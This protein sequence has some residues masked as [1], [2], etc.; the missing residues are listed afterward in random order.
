MPVFVSVEGHGSFT[1]VMT[2]AYQHAEIGAGTEPIGPRFHPPCVTTDVQKLDGISV[3]TDAHR[4]ALKTGAFASVI[5]CNPYRYGFKREAGRTLMLELVRVLRPGGTIIVV[6]HSQNPFC[7]V[8]RIQAIA[9]SL[10]SSGIVLSVEQK[11][12]SAA[13]RFPGHNFR[14]LDG[15]ATVPD[16]E[17]RVRVKP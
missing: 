9:E 17:I 8:A 15:S 11:N 16:V 3:V 4:L 14:R 6:G 7:Q 1:A 2:V 10:S 13:E 12:I 5:L